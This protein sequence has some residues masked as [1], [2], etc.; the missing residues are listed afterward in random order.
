MPRFISRRYRIRD[1]EVSC[2]NKAMIAMGDAII[3][4]THMEYLQSLWYSLIMY[5]PVSGPRA[6]PRNGAMMKPR[7]ARPPCLSLSHRSAI[8]PDL[9]VSV[10]EML[11]SDATYLRQLPR[12]P[13]PQFLPKAV[14]RSE[15]GHYSM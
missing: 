15:V 1:L 12:N 3:I 14:Q 8:V 13:N 5:A 6:G 7:A 2:M 10:F 9:C 11:L 4:T